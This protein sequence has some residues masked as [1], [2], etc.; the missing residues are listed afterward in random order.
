MKT[1]QIIANTKDSE[2]TRKWRKD[3]ICKE[4]IN[5]KE[6]RNEKMEKNNVTERENMYQFIDSN[7]TI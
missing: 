5:W 6:G 4:I 7:I 3:G 2:Y 1:P